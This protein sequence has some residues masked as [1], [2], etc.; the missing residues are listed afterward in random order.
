[1][2]ELKTILLVDDDPRDS[3][4]ILEACLKII[5]PIGL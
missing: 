1:M 4:L 3:D 2:I 5:L